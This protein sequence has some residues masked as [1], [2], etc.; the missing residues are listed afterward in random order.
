MAKEPNDIYMDVVSA[1]SFIEW[2]TKQE[3]A[4]KAG[5]TIQDVTKVFA[6]LKREGDLEKRKN[7]YRYPNAA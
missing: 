4:D 1:I 7:K 6:K 5:V 3:I 2:K